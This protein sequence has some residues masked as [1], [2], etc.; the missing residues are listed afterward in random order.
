MN[1]ILTPTELAYYLQLDRFNTSLDGSFT[2]LTHDDNEINLNWLYKAFAKSNE[3]TNLVIQDNI[4]YIYHD[5]LKEHS[6]ASFPIKFILAY[7]QLKVGF[8]LKGEIKII[9]DRYISL[10]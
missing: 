9:R 1:I 7:V 10:R 5:G 8:E 2:A 4:L 3:N 6:R